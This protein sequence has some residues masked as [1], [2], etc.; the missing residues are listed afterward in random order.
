M[1]LAAAD[2]ALL[3]DVDDFAA[4]RH[5]PIAAHDTS[6]SESGE[7]EK[8]NETHDAPNPFRPRRFPLAPPA[9]KAKYVPIHIGFFADCFLLFIG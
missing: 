7:T 2:L 5:F 8:P 6:A 4:G 1:T 9:T 3:L